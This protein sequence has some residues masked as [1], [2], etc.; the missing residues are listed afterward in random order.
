MEAGPLAVFLDANILFSSA[1][2]RSRG[3]AAFDLLWELA[4]GGRLT[5]VTSVYCHVEAER[6]LALKAP[7]ALGTFRRRMRQVRTVATTGDAPEW[8]DCLP[9]E[10]RPVLAGAL[11][12]GAAVLITGD[13]RHFGP[14]MDRPDLPIR[15]T[16]LRAFLAGGPPDLPA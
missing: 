5:L 14:L 4:A 6:N 11:A 7:D 12:C 15:V 8:A 3:R 1:L 13:R 2:G 16:T 9:P 10:D